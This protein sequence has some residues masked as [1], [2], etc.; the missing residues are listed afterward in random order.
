MV[1]VLQT[2]GWII[3]SKHDFYA[4]SKRT[5]YDGPS[6]VENTAGTGFDLIWAGTNATNVPKE[7]VIVDSMDSNIRLSNTSQ[8]VASTDARF[9]SP[10]LLY[11]IKNGASLT[12]TFEGVAIW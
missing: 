6:R 7:A 3:S 10:N 5:R 12:Y 4:T 8:W 11:T 9:Y 1:K 2:F